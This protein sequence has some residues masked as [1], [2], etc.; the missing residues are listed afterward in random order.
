M[1]IAVL[2]QARQLAHCREAI[3]TAVDPEA[4]ALVG[5]NG[6]ARAHGHLL[7]GQRVR[8]P[9]LSAPT[10]VMRLNDQAFAVAG[11]H[12]CEVLQALVFRP[13]SSHLLA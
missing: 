5:E 2:G 3:C 12:I 1:L 9:Q 6:C 10:T 8:K 7:A 13:V 11:H 4:Y